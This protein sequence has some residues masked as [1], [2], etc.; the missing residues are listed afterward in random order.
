MKRYGKLIERWENN[1]RNT[2]KNKQEI[3][4]KNK[5]LANSMELLFSNIRQHNAEDL[6]KSKKIKLKKEKTK[7][8]TI[9]IFK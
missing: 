3:E 5:L 1:I 9:I 4:N 8:V 2:D 7:W 6:N